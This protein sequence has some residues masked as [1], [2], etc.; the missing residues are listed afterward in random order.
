MN[1]TVIDNGVL[2]AEI[3]PFGAE[4]ISLKKNGT[5]QLWCGDPKVWEGH[6]PILFPICG[7]LNDGKY[8]YKN[9][10]YVLEKHGF[11]KNSIFAVEEAGEDYAV[12]LLKSDDKT[13][14][15]YPFDFE[16][17]VKFSLC[18]SSLNA[19]YAVTN[20]GTGEMYFSVG[21][22]EAYACAGG[23]ENYSVEFECEEVFES[24]LQEN[25]LM[26]RNTEIVAEN[27]VLNLKNEYFIDNSLIFQKLKSRRVRL[28]ASDG[29]DVCKIEFADF[30]YLLLWTI[31][32]AEYI[33]IEPWCGL[34]DYNGERTDFDEKP[35]IIRVDAGMTEKRT[36]TITF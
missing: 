11:A 29:K 5:E 35:G 19:E 26:S 7:G 14:A 15:V 21:A 16:F 10:E 33:C 32:G 8:T 28:A 12:F 1:N 23:I 27:C 6:S 18:G 17:R 24:S 9:T 34:P 4:L 25:G 22:H 36:H 3:T 2:R 30:P 20:T 13:K 31:P